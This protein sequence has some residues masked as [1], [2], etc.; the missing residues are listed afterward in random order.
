MNEHLSTVASEDNLIA[1]DLGEFIEP[2]ATQIMGSAIGWQIREKS[3][4]DDRIDALLANGK[5]ALAKIKMPNPLIQIKIP[6]EINRVDPDFLANFLNWPIHQLASG[7]LFQTISF[8]TEN[9]DCDIKTAF[10][11]AAIEILSNP[12]PLLTKKQKNQI[13]GPL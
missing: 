7:P 12:I 5:D 13:Y 3:N 6:K 9:P 8:E 2:G 10:K 4:I 1:I 11:T